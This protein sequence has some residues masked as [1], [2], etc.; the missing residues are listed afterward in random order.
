M[1]RPDD[2]LKSQ[3]VLFGWRE[4]KVYG[5]H[6]AAVSI[7]CVIANRV[8]IGAGSWLDV[9][10]KAPNLAAQESNTDTPQMYEPTFNRLLHEVE[11]VFD[12]SGKDLS[13]GALYY[14]DL[15]KPITNDWF[16]EKIL[17]NKEQHGMVANMNS[18][19]FFR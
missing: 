4:G 12:G 3:L 2:F 11:S 10:S 8:K 15:A 9:L 1:L 13:A 17:G 7:M 16:K 18:L 6:L 14:A 5:G 19:S